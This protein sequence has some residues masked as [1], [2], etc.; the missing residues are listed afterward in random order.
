MTSCLPGLGR[1]LNKLEPRRSERALAHSEP[2]AAISV[3][4]AELYVLRA[5]RRLSTAPCSV[6]AGPLEAHA[7][8]RNAHPNTAAMLS[9]RT[10]CATSSAYVRRRMH[11]R[12]PPSFACHSCYDLLSLKLATTHVHYPH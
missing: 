12:G 10:R 2:V 11:D 3:G 8:I 9:L 7:V 6:D 1:T 4:A 5:E